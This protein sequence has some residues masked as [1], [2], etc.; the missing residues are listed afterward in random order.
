MKDVYKPV[1]SLH[2]WNLK[3]KITCE[4]TKQPQASLLSLVDAAVIVNT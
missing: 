3:I 2:C 4:S 1:G